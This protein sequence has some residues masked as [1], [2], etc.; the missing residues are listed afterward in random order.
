MT[1]ST[2][3]TEPQDDGELEAAVRSRPWLLV[4]FALI[5]LLIVAPLI[6][7]GPYIHHRLTARSPT[8]VAVYQGFSLRQDPEFRELVMTFEGE[9]P[10]G[11]VFVEL[12][13]QR[14]FRLTELPEAEVAALLP[15]IPERDPPTGANEYSDARSFLT[16]R[17]GKLGFA[18]LHAQSQKFRVA[19]REAGPFA[20]LPCTREE[21]IV[22][23]GEPLRWE[24]PPQGPQDEE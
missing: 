20:P 21:L 13:D 7:M 12:P 19:G 4:I 10:P 3:M 23:F 8:P 1:E 14:R 9:E 24:R 22:S 5:A 17:D 2:E 18:V 6:L 16:Y 15:K 11:A